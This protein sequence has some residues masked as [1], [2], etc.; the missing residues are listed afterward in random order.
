M[1][2][3]AYV[4][5]LSIALIGTGL[6]Q[7]GG[8]GKANRSQPTLDRTNF[9]MNPGPDVVVGDLAGLAQFGSNGTQVGLAMATSTC[10]FGTEDVDY[11]A[12]PSNDHP[13]I[14]QNLYRMSSGNDNAERFEQI[15]QSS[16]MHTFFALAQNLC[17]LGCNGVSGSKLGSGCSDSNTASINSGPNLGSRAWINPFTGNFPA[18]TVTNPNS[19]QGHVHDGVS[20]RILTEA[21]D[22]TTAQNPGATYYA[23][24]QYVTPQEYAWCQSHA[25][26]CNMYNNVSYRR[27]NVAGTS[28]F[29]FAPVGATIESQPAVRAWTGATFVQFEPSP[30]TDGIGIV[31][32][33]VSNPSPGVWHYEYAVYNENLDRAIQSFSLPVGGSVV[34][35]NVGFHAPPQ[36]PGWAADGTAGDAG[37]SS[38]PWTPV[39]ADGA[40]SWH[41]ETLA[42]NPNANAIRWG[43][44]YNFRFDS[45]QAPSATLATIGFFKSGSPIT[46][47]VQG[48]TVVTTNATISGRVLTAG[49]NP[50]RSAT[51]VISDQSGGHLQYATSS[52]LGYYVFSNVQEGLTYTIS[53]SSKRYTFQPL[54]MVVNGDLANADLIA[55]PDSP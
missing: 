2:R 52:S 48:P 46:V 18:A 25:G 41:S 33:K 11:V 29:T 7:V 1:L 38:A 6:A 30:G 10:N 13:I 5:F 45:T 36:H 40:M 14:P 20:H 3:A 24:A 43:T 26:Q 32:Y 17:S 8:S 19:H 42:Q 34:L 47:A 15:G 27:F 16:V 53:I 55:L 22:L 4:L 31:A 9:G 50:L 35:T 28:T 23:E 44:L 21:A 37:F 54:T 39:Q 49:G 51:V 12:A